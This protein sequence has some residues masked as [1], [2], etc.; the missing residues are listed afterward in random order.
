VEKVGV[1]YFVR[2]LERISFLAKPCPYGI[3]AFAGYAGS[4]IDDGSRFVFFVSHDNE[5]DIKPR[6][7][8]LD[9]RGRAYARFR[10]GADYEQAVL[11]RPFAVSNG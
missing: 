11:W 1:A 4:A 10:A 8:C 3:Y 7:F 9:I 5:N 6:W 2:A